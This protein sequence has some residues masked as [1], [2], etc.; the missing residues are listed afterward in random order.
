MDWNLGDSVEMGNA[1]ERVTRERDRAREE[2]DRYHEMLVQESHR[3]AKLTAE[4]DALIKRV[5]EL[6]TERDAAQKEIDRVA[7]FLA[8]HAFL[9]ISWAIRCVK[10]L[11]DNPR[12]PHHNR[13]I[14][15]PCGPPLSHVP[16]ASLGNAH[17]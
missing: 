8:V 10:E 4:C 17:R 9:G 14:R 12:S 7:I 15:E 1:L 3:V 2:R 16:L 5:R 13:A 11:E 6:E